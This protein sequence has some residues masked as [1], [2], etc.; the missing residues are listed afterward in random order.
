MRIKT[1][2]GWIGNGAY[3]LSKQPPDVPAKVLAY[4]SS[5]DNAELFAEQRKSR[6]VWCGDAYAEKQVLDGR[7]PLNQ[8]RVSEPGVHRERTTRRE[9][10][11][12]NQS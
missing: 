10:I 9:S 3:C 11:R 2:Y 8:W 1:V 12:R 4:F 5:I 7:N 6:V